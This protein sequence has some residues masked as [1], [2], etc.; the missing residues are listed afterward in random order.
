M[1]YKVE[2]VSEETGSLKVDVVDEYVFYRSKTTRK[3]PMLVRHPFSRKIVAEGFTDSTGVF[4]ADKLPRSSYKITIEAEKHEGYQ[5]T[6][7][8][9]QAV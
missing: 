6:I 5:N 8:I 9:D 1:P 2:A 3:M 7:V 4:R